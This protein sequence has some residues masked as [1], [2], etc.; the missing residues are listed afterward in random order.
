LSAGAEGQYPDVVRMALALARVGMPIVLDRAEEVFRTLLGLDDVVVG[1]RF[2]Q[3]HLDDLRRDRPDSVAS[4][5]WDPILSIER[6][7]ADGLARIEHVE[8]TG[9]PA[10]WGGTFS[11]CR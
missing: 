4:V 3:V 7:T 1:P 9:T 8:R 2:G 11:G 6:V 5:R 10:G